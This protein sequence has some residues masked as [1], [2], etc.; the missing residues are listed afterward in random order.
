MWIYA[1]NQKRILG[2]STNNM[3][4]NTGWQDVSEEVPDVLTNEHGVPLYEL[5]DGQITPRSQEDVDADYVP[6]VYKPSAEELLGALM[7]GIEDA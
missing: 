3:L 4:G 1:N 5:V 2:Y 7:E 6:P